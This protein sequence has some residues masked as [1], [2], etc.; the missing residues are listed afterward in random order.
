VQVGAAQALQGVLRA[1]VQSRGGD[2]GAMLLEQ[3]LGRLDALRAVLQTDP[4]RIDRV[5][6]GLHVARLRARG[7]PPGGTNPM[8]LMTRWGV[9]LT[10]TA[11][12]IGCS[13]GTTTNNGGGDT[14]GG[15]DGV[16]LF[17][18]GG[19]DTTDTATATD[20]GG[21][22][23]DPDTSGGD[24]T[25]T[26]AEPAAAGA[27]LVSGGGVSAS[28]NYTL[29]HTIGAPTAALPASISQNYRLQGGLVGIIGGP[30]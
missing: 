18:G 16:V 27:A 26:P 7:A 21:D 13:D 8:R 11:L 5:A 10:L 25:V 3:M 12:A 23:G 1:D 20:G 29:L 17:D 19:T 30:Q 6:A 28:T 15:E 9:A 2:D 4:M 14:G 24:D 22:A